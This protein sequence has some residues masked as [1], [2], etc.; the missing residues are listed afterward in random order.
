V[1]ASIPSIGARFA[2]LRAIDDAAMQDYCEASDL[3]FPDPP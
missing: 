3:S 2:P 1:P